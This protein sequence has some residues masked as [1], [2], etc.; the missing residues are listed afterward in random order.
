MD[1][2]VDLRY[3]RFKI[4]VRVDHLHAPTT[5]QLSCAGWPN[6]LLNND[7]CPIKF[8]LLVPMDEHRGNRVIKV[9]IPYQCSP[10]AP[11]HRRHRRREVAALF[12]ILTLLLKLR[13][14]HHLEC[15]A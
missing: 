3:K 13:D 14:G 1:G 15:L 8:K 6:P 10:T 2:D 9:S 11:Y 12:Y 4:R 7:G 5:E